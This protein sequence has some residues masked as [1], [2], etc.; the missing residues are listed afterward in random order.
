MGLSERAMIGVA[1]A[2]LCGRPDIA[3]I[4]AK[5]RR[6]LEARKNADGVAT[7]DKMLAH[8]A[9]EAAQALK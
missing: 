4:A 1:T 7:L 3:E 2:H 5:Y 8:I 9:A 6:E